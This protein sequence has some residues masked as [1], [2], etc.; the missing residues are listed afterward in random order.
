MRAERL[1]KATATLK[2]DTDHA[3]AGSV[4]RS[5]SSPL[6][7]SQGFLLPTLV[8]VRTEDFIYQIK[9]EFL[10]RTKIA[11]ALMLL[12]ALV[13]TLSAQ[14]TTTLTLLTHD[15]FNVTEDVLKAFEEES[16]IMVSILRVGDAG[17]MVNQAILS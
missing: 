15:S 1:C 8:P 10:M 5:P 13:G 16:G 4:W 9:R 12:V 3:D 6:S 7:N 2:P 11:I 17:Q 14:E